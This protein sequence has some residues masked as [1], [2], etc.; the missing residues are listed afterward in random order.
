MALFDNSSAT[1]ALEFLE[2]TDL[3]RPEIELFYK[4][5]GR[6]DESEFGCNAVL[7]ALETVKIWLSSV[8]RNEI[9]L[10]IVG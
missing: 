1:S 10:L 4:S 7:S 9:G 8:S 6:E 3:Q 2:N 5:E